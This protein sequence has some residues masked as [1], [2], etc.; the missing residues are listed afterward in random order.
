MSFAQDFLVSPSPK[1]VINLVG[2]TKSEGLSSAMSRK[3]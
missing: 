3:F 2:K 1:Q